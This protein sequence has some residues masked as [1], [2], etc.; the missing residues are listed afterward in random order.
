MI[1]KAADLVNFR[2][3]QS[4][5]VAVCCILVENLL[6]FQFW[7]AIC[8]TIVVNKFFLFAS[9]LDL[10]SSLAVLIHK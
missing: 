9:Y 10:K 1:G 8:G 6:T 3:F 7:W 4:R 5:S 2:D